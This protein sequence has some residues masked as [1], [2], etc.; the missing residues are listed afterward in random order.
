MTRVTLKERLLQGVFFIDGAMG[1]Q[2]IEAGAPVG[3]CNDSLNIDSPETVKTVHQKYIDAG[4]DAIITNTFGANGLVLKRHGIAEKIHEINLAAAGL[5]RSVAGEAKYVLGDIGPCGDFLEPLGMVKED[6]LK[7]AFADQARGLLAGGV[8]GFIIE[9]M[10]ALEEIKVAI[11]AVRSI[12]DLPVLVSLAYDPA[13]DAAR[14]M[15]GVA[16]AQAAECLA[17]LGIAALGFNCGTLDMPGYIRLA[18]NYAEALEGTG[19]LLLAEPNAGRPELDGD[20]TLYKLEPADYADALAQIHQAG[21]AVLGGCCGT[22]PA[23]IAAAVE[24][25]R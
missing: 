7:A 23:H 13:G 11:E 1:T 15:M 14:T 6:D 19:V 5:A 18:Q 24:K 17:S 4:V 16:P 12:S 10:S 2:L 22:T 25:I 9:T 21:A 3:C 8:D 20:K